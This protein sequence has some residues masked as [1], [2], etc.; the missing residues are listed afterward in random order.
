MFVK[1]RDVTAFFLVFTVLMGTVAIRCK[2]T[3][4][5]VPSADPAG[6]FKIIGDD[7]DSDTSD[8]TESN[9][10]EKPDHTNAS[11][12]EGPGIYHVCT[13]YES[14]MEVKVSNRSDKQ[15]RTVPSDQWTF[16]KTAGRLEIET[17]IDDDQEM[18]IVYG[19][20]EVPWA[21]QMTESLEPGSVKVLLDDRPGVRGVDFETDEEKGVIRF[22]KKELCHDGLEYYISFNYPRDRSQPQIGRGGA[23]GNH[24]DRKAVRRFLGLP[25]EEG[26]GKDQK[27]TVGTNASPTS[28][29]RV[30]SMVRP[31]QSESIRVAVADRKKAGDLNWLEKGEDY[32]YNEETGLITLL[33]EIVI[34]PEI[35][36]MFVSGIPAN[37]GI[38]NF[39]KT[40]APESTEVWLNGRQLI[41]GVGYTVDV[42]KGSV[43][44]LDP[45]IKDKGA[46]FYIRSGGRSFGNGAAP[47]LSSDPTREKESNQKTIIGKR[48]S[49]NALPTRNSR[50]FKLPQSMISEGLQ[51]CL[52]EKENINNT[53]L[54][55][56]DEDYSF[57]QEDKLITLIKDIPV[58]FDRQQLVVEGSL[59]YSH[60]VTFTTETNAPPQ[61]DC[62][63]FYWTT[64]HYLKSAELDYVVLDPEGGEFYEYFMGQSAQSR[65]SLSDFGSEVTGKRSDIFFDKPIRF[66]LRVSEGPMKIPLDHGFHFDFYR[67]NEDGTIDRN[68][69]IATIRACAEDE[70]LRNA[71]VIPPDIDL[72]DMMPVNIRGSR[73]PDL[74]WQSIS[75]FHNGQY[76]RCIQNLKKVVAEQPKRNWSWYLLGRAFFE[77]GDMEG[78]LDTFTHLVS[79]CP[80]S[81]YLYEKGRVLETLGREEEA[82]IE[83]GKAFEILDSEHGYK[84]FIYADETIE[85]R[86][87]RTKE[88]IIKLLKSDD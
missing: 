12:M 6:N 32:I 25:E 53:H 87:P 77:S 38:F 40:I 19:K 69:P 42:A 60:V 11:P 47:S 13:V 46:E 43:T 14:L 55:N 29:P 9:G 86:P 20:L 63:T 2:A 52:E 37:R 8:K 78:A 30:Y 28:D 70:A 61:F 74:H 24:S 67:A 54:L 39:G 36:F 21:W 85:G 10:E 1:F 71:A 41:E 27:N 62:W 4:T 7:P 88:E 45:A 58:D 72:N 81:P 51:V 73:K 57:N 26:P 83:Y 79:I 65:S 33:K 49:R 31:M 15:K 64:P 75:V 34:D 3:P 82:A 66:V 68:H 17:P 80:W 5:T 44:V 18:V 48:V 35:S 76:D 22:L 23:I 16:D 50:V 59:I 56:R 84:S